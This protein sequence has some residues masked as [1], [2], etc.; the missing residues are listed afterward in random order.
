MLNE[1]LVHR[2]FRQIEYPY[3]YRYEASIEAIEGSASFVE[4]QVLKQCND[5]LY[6]MRLREILAQVSTFSNLIPIRIISYDIGALFLTVCKEQQLDIN[7]LIGPMD[8]I[9]YSGLIDLVSYQKKEYPVSPD[10][11]AFFDEDQRM[12]RSKF[13]DILQHP[14]AVWQGDFELL[15]LNVYSARYLD[16][17]VFSEH[18]IVITSYSIHYT[19]LYDKE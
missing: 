17:Y 15:G 12:L 11:K 7:W 4:L 18:F 8:D 19:K 6:T 14:A 1:F 16:G 13:D 9:F 10:I 5:T 2:M 3:E